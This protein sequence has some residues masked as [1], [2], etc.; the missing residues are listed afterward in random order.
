MK[1]E[2]ANLS[3]SIYTQFFSLGATIYDQHEAVLA[4]E[5]LGNMN[6]QVWEEARQNAWIVRNK[7][8]KI[9]AQ[10]HSTL[11]RRSETTHT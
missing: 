5:C 9:H 3:L 7:F 6:P 1:A 10:L 11:Q 8:A 2:G 4:L